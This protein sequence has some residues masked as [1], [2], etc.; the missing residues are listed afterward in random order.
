MNDDANPGSRQQRG[1]LLET[2]LAPTPEVPAKKKRP[3][4]KKKKKKQEQEQLKQA[5]K[6]NQQLVQSVKLKES[7]TTAMLAKMKKDINV[8]PRSEK[9]S[10]SNQTSSSQLPDAQ[11]KC[12]SQ[13]VDKKLKPSNE[14]AWTSVEKSQKVVPVP[15]WETAATK[16]NNLPSKLEKATTSTWETAGKPQKVVPRPT[17]GTVEISRTTV[18]STPTWTTASQNHELKPVGSKQREVS[19]ANDWRNHSMTRNISSSGNNRTK[20][21]LKDS[22]KPL[23][24]SNTGGW[25][26]LGASTQSNGGHAE[27]WPSLGSNHSHTSNSPVPQSIKSKATQGNWQAKGASVQSTWGKGLK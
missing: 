25:P 24:V 9:K 23:P 1:G 22:E 12:A 15:T 21:K 7:D 27:L 3:P 4:R 8:Q 19:T 5:E 16:T 10:I 18:P 13:S 11:N 26:T 20:S 2:D 17:W 6:D 14:S